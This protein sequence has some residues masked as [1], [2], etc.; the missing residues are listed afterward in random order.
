MVHAYGLWHAAGRAHSVEI[1]IDGQ[2]AGG[3]YFV[4]IGSM[5]YG[6][7]MFSHRTDASKLALA[8]WWRPAGRAAWPGSTVSSTPGIWP[9]SGAR[10]L[11]RV[12]FLHHLPLALGDPDIRDWTYD[13]SHWAALGVR[14]A[15]LEEDPV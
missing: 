4:S 12:D 3:L 8:A 10:E 14:P 9:A 11:P 13:P 2:L 7:S 15:P 6:E 5:V 1:W